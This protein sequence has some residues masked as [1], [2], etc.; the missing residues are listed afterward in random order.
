[1]YAVRRLPA[2]IFKANPIVMARRPSSS[3]AT[4]SAT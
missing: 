2:G 3:A 4:G 1:M